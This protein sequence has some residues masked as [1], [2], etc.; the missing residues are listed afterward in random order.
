MKIF[1]MFRS[2][3][4]TFK[5][6]YKTN[7]KFKIGFNIFLLILILGFIISYFSPVDTKTWYVV[8]KDKPPS[9]N[10]LL[11]TSTMGRDIFWELC[12]SIKNSLVI[13]LIAAT[14]GSH[15]ALVLGLI[16][17]IKG[18]ILDRILMFITD[19]F[20][21][22]PGFPLLMVI[23]TVFKEVM[24]IPLM[25]GL[26]GLIFWRAPLRAVRS[27]TL[28]LRERSFVFTAR[29]SGMGMFR[30]LLY[31]FMPHLLAWHLVN[32][33]NTTLHAIAMESGLAI[34]GLSVLSENTLGVML[35]WSINSFS[36]LYRGIWWWVIAPVVTLIL[37]FS[38]LYLLSVGLSEYLHPRGG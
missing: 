34:L 2:I 13:A 26:M 3:I 33:T 35:F 16:A 24:S 14:I 18:G 10:Y 20:I 32:L 31:E 37:I 38:S 6:I 30:I 11:G 22:I 36:A 9:L 8:P 17:G 4:R 25:G 12:S 28:S 15:I 1:N 7:I 21:I 29:L 5:N 27:M 23:M 19:T